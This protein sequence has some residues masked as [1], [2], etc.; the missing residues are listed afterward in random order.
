MFELNNIE[1]YNKALG[2]NESLEKVAMDLPRNTYFLANL[3]KKSAGAIPLDIAEAST[4]ESLDERKNSFWA[5]C[6]AI[7]ECSGWIE[8]AARQGYID[9]SKRNAFRVSLDDLS[10]MLQDLI[11]NSKVPEISQN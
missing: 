7:R 5:A 8:V 3:L 10:G 4:Q 1:L 2:L 9:E 11:R 6:N